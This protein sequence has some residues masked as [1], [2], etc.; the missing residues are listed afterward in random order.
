MVLILL[1]ELVIFFFFQAED[2]IRDH[3]VTGVQTCALPI[4]GGAL[5]T[6]RT[7]PDRPSLVPLSVC[8]GAAARAALCPR[9]ATRAAPPPGSAGSGSSSRGSCRCCC[10][11]RRRLRDQPTALA[12]ESPPRIGACRWWPNGHPKAG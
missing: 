4:S 1:F 5:R 2:G 3:C 12:R 10:A 7:R 9:T 8:A 6:P 11:G